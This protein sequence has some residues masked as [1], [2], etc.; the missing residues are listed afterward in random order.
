M[1]N[2]LCFQKLKFG[3]LKFPGARLFNMGEETT[4]V[5]VERTEREYYLPA[6]AGLSGE[7]GPIG[8]LLTRV[9]RRRGEKP[10]LG[11]R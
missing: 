6:T 5:D 9:F 4:D 1:N 11:R 2:N 10:A 3:I 7:L 8:R